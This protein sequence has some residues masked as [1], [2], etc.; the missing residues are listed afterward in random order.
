MPTAPRGWHCPYLRRPFCFNNIHLRASRRLL[1]LMVP[2]VI[3]RPRSVSSCRCLSCR[4]L[5][6]ADFIDLDLLPGSIISL[7]L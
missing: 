4:E 5:F 3:F 7:V 1:L 2:S 6:F